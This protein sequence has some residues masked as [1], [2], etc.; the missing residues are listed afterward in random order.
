MALCTEFILDH[1]QPVIQK[2]ELRGQDRV[3]AFSAGE[4]YFVTLDIF[5]VIH[6]G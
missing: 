5:A 2:V 6:M 4:N 1:E 3:V